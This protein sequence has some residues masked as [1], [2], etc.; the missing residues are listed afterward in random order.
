[1]RTSEPQSKTDTGLSEIAWLSSQDKTQM[2]HSLMHHI[3]IDSLR[4]CYHKLDGKKAIGADRISKEMYGEKLH[5][6]L[7]GLI[8]RM[9]RMGYRPQPV[10]EVR[11]PKEGK[12]GATRPLGISN[13]E[14]KIVQKRMQEVLESLYDP[15]FVEWSYGFRPG[16]GAHDAIKALSSYLYKHE[17]ETVIDV[18]LANFFGTIDHELLK[19]FLLLKIK[20]KKFIRYINRMFKAGVLSEGEL[21]VSDEGVPQGSCCSPVLANIYAHYVIDE[22]LE[23]TVKP[24]MQGKIQAFR[25]ADDLI[26]CFRYEQDATR[27]RRAL[28]RR[29]EKYRLSLNEDKTKMVKF[30]KNSQRKGEKQEAFNFLGF[31]FYLGRSL[32]GVT[33]P[34]LKTEGKRFRSKLQRV[35]AWCQENRNEG[36]TLTLWK[37]F[38]AKL[39]GHIQYYGVSHNSGR[40]EEFIAQARRI[41]F[42]WLN[43]RSQRRSFDWNK[44]ER[45]LKLHSLPKVKVHHKLF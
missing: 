15:I 9:K 12:R 37:T 45:F 6:N 39:R 4:G 33:V 13:F 42:K 8:A 38:C 30:S 17:V 40:V 43:R 5:E 41:I 16:R 14:D 19:D 7:D 26:I 18:D 44:F 21:V 28:S 20:D 29:L 36:P 23:E 3:N 22:W 10:R 34:K 27:V 2:F 32:T 35:K 11:I 24:L 25:Y 1:M 31:T